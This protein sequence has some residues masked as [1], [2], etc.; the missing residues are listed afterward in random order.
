MNELL[1][2]AGL[3]IGKSLIE[4]HTHYLWKDIVTCLITVSTYICLLKNIFQIKSRINEADI[5]SSRNNSK[6]CYLVMYN[7]ICSCFFIIITVFICLFSVNP[8][9]KHYPQTSWGSREK[10]TYRAEQTWEKPGRWKWRW[11]LH[12]GK[13]M[14]KATTGQGGHH[15]LWEGMPRIEE[16]S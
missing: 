2:A 13:R 4:S 7:S 9:A 14:G 5:A 3:D 10:A 12:T 15:S 16:K 1:V 11:L 6:L 8:W